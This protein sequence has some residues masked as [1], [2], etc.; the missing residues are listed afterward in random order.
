MGTSPVP[1]W[2]GTA[3][4]SWPDWVGPF[5]PR[6]T[7][8]TQMLSYYASQFP[9]VEI[10]S[11]FYRT[12]A[13]GQLTKL[14]EKT[15]PGFRFSLKAPRTVSHDHSVHDLRPFQQAA[16]EL[17][18]RD[19]LIG[20]V[21][22]FP[23]SFHD[24][25]KNRDWLKRVHAGLQPYSTWIEFRHRSWARPRLGDWLRQRGL[26]LAFVDAPDLPQLFPRGIADAGVSRVYVRLHSRLAEKWSG[27]GTAR[28]AYDFSDIELKE[29]IG[30]LTPLATHLSD[31][32][33]I[34]NNCHGG[35]AIANAKR[36]AQL[37]RNHAPE[38]HIV[39]PPADVPPIQGI[40][41][42]EMTI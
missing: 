36:I 26:N 20:L 32:H 16:A 33:L 15:A 29:W 9:C 3:G 1:V 37:I 2:L 7:S 4:Y 14:F 35:Q 10:N 23:E 18:A 28:Y 39:D 25:Q 38:F 31:V 11:T 5:Y 41:F 21:V 34:F 40:L 24:T 6:G 30:Q 13:P 22:Q 19:A 42:E 17:A 27:H 12:P 8:Q